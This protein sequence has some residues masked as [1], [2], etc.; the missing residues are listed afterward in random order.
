MLLEHPNSAS[1]D[2]SGPQKRQHVEARDEVYFPGN[3]SDIFAHL[4]TVEMHV[5]Q[6]EVMWNAIFR[7]LEDD[8]GTLGMPAQPH[9]QWD[10]SQRTGSWH[11][12][13]K[14]QLQMR[15]TFTF[16]SHYVSNQSVANQ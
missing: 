9:C 2:L 7:R 12:P 5:Q 8:F 1:T 6:G 16:S 13:C 4:L 11:P 10:R 3:H 14:P 15:K